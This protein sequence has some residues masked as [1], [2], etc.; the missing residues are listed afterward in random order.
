MTFYVAALLLSLLAVGFVLLPWWRDRTEQRD[1]AFLDRRRALAAVGG[2]RL[3]E[4]DEERAAGVID[5][6]DYLQLRREQHQQLLAEAES[7]A[8]TPVL[9]STCYVGLLL[10]ALLIPITAGTFYWQTGHLAD[11]RIQSLLDQAQGERRRGIDN[12]ATI[13]TLRQA[14]E[15]RLAAVA[16]DDGRRRFILARLQL[17]T[18]NFRAA[19]DQYRQLHQQF[20]DDA[21]LTGQFAQAL[22]LAEGRRM[23]PEVE[24]LA[25]T[26]VALDPA[27]TTALGLLGIDA[28]ERADYR[29]AILHWRRLL[30]TLPAESPER[31]VV[32]QG[33]AEAQRRLG[34]AAV[35]GPALEI[36]V[37]LAPALA[38]SLPP[39]ATLFVFAR[40]AGGAP[41]PLAAARLAP[42]AWPV[43]IRLDDSN[44]MAPGADLSSTD[45]VEVVAR[46]TASGQV[47][48]M[49]GDLEGRAGPVELT[50]GPVPVPVT[51]DKTL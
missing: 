18:G 49:A 26:A 39:D 47:R 43:K 11:W 23:T 27:Q 12:G 32:A 14:L 51:I 50:D 42:D 36:T 45:Q 30:Q 46:L 15:Q 9:R 48:P 44:A 29:E 41:M 4:L 13:V 22:F 7:E 2:A 34:P 3:A 21:A 24:R 28:F 31:G 17:E 5:E 19:S 25:R 40:A 8:A 20:P 38:G 6:R 10:V 37:D 33:L 16:D 35:T 1:D